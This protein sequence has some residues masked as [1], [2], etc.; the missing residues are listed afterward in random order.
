MTAKAGRRLNRLELF[1]ETERLHEDPDNYDVY[2]PASKSV[3]LNEE[4]RSGRT[5]VTLKDIIEGKLRGQ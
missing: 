5:V 2:V 3:K 1:K 4:I